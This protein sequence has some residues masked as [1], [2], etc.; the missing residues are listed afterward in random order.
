[1]V[2][3]QILEDRRMRWEINKDCIG[4][5]RERHAIGRFVLENTCRM[6]VSALV[7][8]LS[9]NQRFSFTPVLVNGHARNVA[10]YYRKFL[11]MVTYEDVAEWI[12]TYI[13][14]HRLY[15]QERHHYQV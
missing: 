9:R 10:F 2:R 7:Q 12:K 14:S 13:R 8:R 6:P 15:E 3:L 4:S 11:I 1:M 5:R